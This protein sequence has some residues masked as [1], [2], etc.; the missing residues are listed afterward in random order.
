MFFARPDFDGSS[1][2]ESNQVVFTRQKDE[3][4]LVHKDSPYQFLQQQCMVCRAKT[5]TRC[6]CCHLAYYCNKKC[7]NQDY[8]LH[9]ELC[10]TTTKN[11]NIDLHY[12]RHN[13]YRYSFQQNYGR[14]NKNY[15][16]LQRY[17]VF[18][19]IM[20]NGSSITIDID[21]AALHKDV[22]LC[23]F[24]L[25]CG[26]VPRDLVECYKCIIA[27]IQFEIINQLELKFG[28]CNVL[29]YNELLHVAADEYLYDKTHSRHFDDIT[30]YLKTHSI[31]DSD[32]NFYRSMSFMACY[33]DKL[34][35]DHFKFLKILSFFVEQGYIISA[36]ILDYMVTTMSPANF[37]MVWKNHVILSIN[38]RKQVLQKEVNLVFIPEICNIVL[39]YC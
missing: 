26:S 12:D 22:S 31:K 21:K 20:L 1:E 24:L 13:P 4:L 23:R 10:Q 29:R 19:D 8:V 39:F 2:D 37:F 25:Y 28:H 34:P 7:Q 9:K 38:K 6:S 30:K 17:Q 11:L 33:L 5:T 18:A 36:P 16:K 3:P 14:Y 32:E 15:L 35:A 27:P